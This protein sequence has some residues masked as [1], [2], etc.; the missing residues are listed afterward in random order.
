MSQRSLIMIQPMNLFVSATLFS[1]F[2]P[3]HKTIKPLLKKMQ[4]SLC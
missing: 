1:Q 4:F 2:P 3:L